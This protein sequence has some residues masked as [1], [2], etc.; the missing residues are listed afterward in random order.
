MG[1]AYV[2]GLKLFH[3]CF[4]HAAMLRPDHHARGIFVRRFIVIGWSLFVCNN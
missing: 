1:G 3:W 4:D 2:V